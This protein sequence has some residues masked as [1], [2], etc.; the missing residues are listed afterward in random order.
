MYPLYVWEATSKINFHGYISSSLWNNSIISELPKIE[1]APC[2]PPN[3]QKRE[4]AVILIQTFARITG[5]LLLLEGILSLCVCSWFTPPRQ[6][7]LKISFPELVRVIKVI[8]G[9]PSL[10]IDSAIKG[11]GKT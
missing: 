5:L 1:I 6:A 9:P 3:L 10:N 8:L 11:R 7:E 2:F 4:T